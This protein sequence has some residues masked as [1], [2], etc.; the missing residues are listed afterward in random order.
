VEIRL[1]GIIYDVI[2]DVR[3]AL[4]GLLEPTYRE[5][6]LGRAEVRQVFSVSRFGQVA[7]CAVSEGKL[8]RGA[9]L[10]LVRDQVVV[11]Q[12]H[13]ASLRRFKDDVREVVAGTECGVSLENF[14]DVKAGDV[15]EAYELEQILRRLETRP[16]E[17]ERRV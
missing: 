10:R 4:E 9:K 14:Q 15:I 7:G 16:Q 6:P 12:G 2:A 3:A 17:V 11:H 5:K 8:V 13:I 1:Y